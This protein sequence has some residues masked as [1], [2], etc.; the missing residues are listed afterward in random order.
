M[1]HYYQTTEFMDFLRRRIESGAQL[2]HN[3]AGT[4]AA[5]RPLILEDDAVFVHVRMGDIA[6]VF[7]IPFA[8]YDAAL[9]QILGSE[10]ESKKYISSDTIDHPTCVALIRKYNLQPVTAD[11]VQTILFASKCR[12]MVLSQGSFSWLLSF[13]RWMYRRSVGLDDGTVIRSDY[14]RGLPWAGDMLSAFS[15]VEIHHNP[16]QLVTGERL[17]YLALKWIGTPEDFAYNP[18][19]NINIERHLSWPTQ[20]NS[21]IVFGYTHHLEWLSRAVPRFERPFVLITH[22]SDM[23]VHDTPHVQT[24][25]A[26]PKLIRWYT[27]NLCFQHPKLRILPIGIANRQWQHGTDFMQFINQHHCGLPFDKSSISKT[28]DVYMCVRVET[29]RELRTPCVDA[30]TQK[31]VACLPIVPPLEN[32]MRMA[33]Y[34]F[35]VCPPGNGRDTHRL[36]EA[37]VLGCVP[38]VVRDAFI[39]TLLH[40]HPALPIIVLNQ[41]TDFNVDL[42]PPYDSFDFT[43][44]SAVM[45]VCH[46]AALFRIS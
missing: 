5:F 23:E 9:Q 32:I 3:V 38:I 6:D 44:V 40:E 28:N 14:T 20:Y 45:N 8:Y 22:N 42:L 15:N 11:A 27:S 7:D 30:I 2:A 39:D 21:K 13:C 25:L 16:Y 43:S 41:W 29:N 31:G 17:Q 34:R 37:L 46:Y 18:A 10:S 4:C 24:I 19:I 36:W 26:S 35:C 1:E 12:H 33:T